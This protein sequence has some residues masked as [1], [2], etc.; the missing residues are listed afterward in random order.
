MAVLPNRANRLFPKDKNVCHGEPAY[1]VVELHQGGYATNGANRCSAL[2]STSLHTLQ[3]FSSHLLP[4][5]TPPCP[6]SGR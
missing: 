1:Y 3:W 4:F 5:L 2:L 6:Y